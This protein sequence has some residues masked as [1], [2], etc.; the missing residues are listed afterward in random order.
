[1][2]GGTA[3]L[4]T[5]QSPKE[6]DKHAERISMIAKGTPD[7]LKARGSS[8]T[9]ARATIRRVCPRRRWYIMTPA[10][11]K[12]LWIPQFLP[13]VRGEKSL[14]ECVVRQG[15]SVRPVNIGGPYEDHCFGNLAERR[16][17]GGG[18]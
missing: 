8:R 10:R 4:S 11:L 14:G 5:T 1:M 12:H 7:R 15:K 13:G 17:P 9:A 16:R 6:T 2:T 3:V 18:G